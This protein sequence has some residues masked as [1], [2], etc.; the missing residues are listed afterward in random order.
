MPIVPAPL[1]PSTVVKS[2]ANA[3]VPV[4]LTL[5]LAVVSIVTETRTSLISIA[6]PVKVV[7]FVA[8]TFTEVNPSMVF[9]SAA[10]AVESP[11]AMVML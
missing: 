11:A 3:V 8:T 5:T 2:V 7:T 10:A 6:E 9:K 1:F 4:T